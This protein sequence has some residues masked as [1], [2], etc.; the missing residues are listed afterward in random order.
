MKKF[1]KYLM[2]AATVT[3][4]ALSTG[5][6]LKVYAAEAPA[7][8]VAGQPVDLTYAAE[9]ALPSVVHIKYVQNSKTKTV[10]VQDDP[11]GGF[12]DPF[13]FFGNPGGGSRQQRVQTPKREATGSGV[14]ISQDG[15][16]VTNN[17][18]VDGASA[19]IVSLS[20]GR[21]LPGKLVGA[22][23]L[24]DL[25]V[26]QV[27]DGNLPTAD[28]GDSD[29]TVVGESVIAIGNP[30]GLEFQGSVTSG[31]VSALNR[32]LG[33]DDARIKLVQTDAAIN[34]GNSGGALV[35]MDGKV[36]GINSAK[37]VANG[38]EGI[39]L[40]IPSN[41]VQ[42]VISAIMEKGYVP[43]PYL[44]VSI[45][46]QQSA[47]RYGYQL[48]LKKGVYI[49]QVVPGGPADQAGLRKGDVITAIDGDD[50]KGVSDLR[51]KIAEH[52]VGDKVELT[53]QRGGQE[54]KASLTLEEMPQDNR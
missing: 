12:F 19:L 49:F 53:I 39:G 11:W 38:V 25:A 54:R 15:Y 48:N 40:A 20:D 33:D 37:I 4:L 24:T 34:P 35:N 41:A 22:D 28:F 3:A 8:V 43:R 31:V 23:A 16:I 21:S 10:E 1:S 5:A 32:T 45:F 29:A 2:S 46:D 30:M 13:G 50:I 6:F 17:H 52:S 18:V 9:K 44:G 47:A 27:D 51:A 26:V 42:N 7:S 14:I 36:I